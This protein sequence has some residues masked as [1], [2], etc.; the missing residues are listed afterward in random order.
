MLKKHMMLFEERKIDGRTIKAV[1]Y[2]S[3]F[4]CALG[5][6]WGCE[7]SRYKKLNK[8]IGECSSNF[9]PTN[10]SIMFVNVK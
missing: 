4:D 2:I 6:G 5:Y 3:C 8:E 9:R 10:D 1:E 7:L